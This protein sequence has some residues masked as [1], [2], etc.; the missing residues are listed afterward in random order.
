[1][2]TS[3]AE[4]KNPTLKS[5]VALNNFLRDCTQKQAE[6]LLEEERKGRAR[7][8]F[9]LRIHSRINKVRADGERSKLQG[10]V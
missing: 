1:M 2:T 4:I 9:L 7:K 5:W 10:G 6:K 8:M 3:K